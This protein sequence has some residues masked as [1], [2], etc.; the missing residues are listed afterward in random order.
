MCS[1]HYFTA[2]TILSKSTLVDLIGV[3]R[4]VYSCGNPERVCR[5][6]RRAGQ[7]AGE[8]RTA[9]QAGNATA[10]SRAIRSASRPLER[11]TARRERRTASRARA[12]AGHAPRGRQRRTRHGQAARDSGHASHATGP[13]R[14]RTHQTR[15]IDRVP[16][17]CR[18]ARASWSPAAV[19]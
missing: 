7:A 18:S 4:L 5:G 9:R 1:L 14:A 12:Q 2:P 11:R 8:P 15:N 16:L 3:R 13:H 10:A 17:C 19:S 6:Q